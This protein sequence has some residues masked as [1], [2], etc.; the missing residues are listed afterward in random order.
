[1]ILKSKGY[2]NLYNLSGGYLTYD[3]YTYKLNSE[4]V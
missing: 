1:M 3:A 2:T 4:L